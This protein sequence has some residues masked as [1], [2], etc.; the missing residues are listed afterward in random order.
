MDGQV[1]TRIELRDMFTKALGRDLTIIEGEVLNRVISTD[2]EHRVAFMD[3]MKECLNK[4]N[5]DF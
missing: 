4:V 2:Q 3:M 1:E 5:G